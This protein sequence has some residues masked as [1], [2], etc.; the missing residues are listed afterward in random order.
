M[1]LGYIL[2]MLDDCTYYKLLLLLSSSFSYYAKWRFIHV[3]YLATD[4]VIQISIIYIIKINYR[5]LNY[6]LFF[7]GLKLII[8]ESNPKPG[9]FVKLYL[10]KKKWKI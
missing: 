7:V 3:L 8:K 5:I 4:A 10:K 6:L 9:D 2:Q 1:L